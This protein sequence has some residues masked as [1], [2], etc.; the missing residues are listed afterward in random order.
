MKFK[1]QYE[2]TVECTEEEFESAKREW[3]DQVVPF[4]DHPPTEEWT[5]QEVQREVFQYMITSSHT[6]AFSDLVTETGY[7]ELEWEV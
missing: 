5:Q 1:V 7:N 3:E 4:M 2:Y 6:G